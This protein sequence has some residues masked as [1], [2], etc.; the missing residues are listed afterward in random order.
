[1]IKLYISYFEPKDDARQNELFDAV[2][3]N[4]ENPLIDQIVML[5]ESGQEW[6]SD[7]IK[8]I[9]VKSRPSYQ[10][11]FDLFEDD[12][13]NIIANTDIYFNETLSK[14]ENITDSTC[15]AITRHEISD[16]KIKPFAEVN[17]DCPPYYSQDVWVFRGKCKIDD[18]HTVLAMNNATNQHDII[19]HTMGVAG[20]ENVLAALLKKKYSV[21]NPHSHIICIHNH[22][23][24]DRPA[25]SHRMTGSRSRWGIIGQGIVKNYSL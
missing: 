5:D 17:T 2:T 25:Y 24:T 19:K 10:D 22:A 7:K 9:K 20:C 14:V 4:I 3:K 11:F 23:S 15:Y 6:Q 13:I 8:C 21:R 12:C 18:C 16:G 1:M